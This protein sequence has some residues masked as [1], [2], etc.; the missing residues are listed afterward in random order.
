MDIM[1][2]IDGPE[3][4]EAENLASSGLMKNL[5]GFIFLLRTRGPGRR[6]TG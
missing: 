2:P 1:V 4:P 3:P 6:S 5:A